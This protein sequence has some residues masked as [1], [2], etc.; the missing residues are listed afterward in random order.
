VFTGVNAGHM[1]RVRCDGTP[2]FLAAA[3]WSF[4]MTAQAAP[5]Q[6]L[7]LYDGSGTAGRQVCA[8]SP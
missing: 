2:F 1:L 5:E 4:D 8:G 6:M 3:W 7:W